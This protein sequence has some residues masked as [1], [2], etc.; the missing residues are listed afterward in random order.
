MLSVVRE[1]SSR[2]PARYYRDSRCR[3][4][5]I[6]GPDLKLAGAPPP[7]LVRRRWRNSRPCWPTESG[8]QAPPGH[9]GGEDV[10]DG[11]LGRTAWMLR[12]T[13]M[14]GTRDAACAR[15]RRGWRWRGRGRGNRGCPRHRRRRG[16]P[17]PALPESAPPSDCPTGSSISV[18][19]CRRSGLRGP[20]DRGPMHGASAG[21][22]R[23]AE[24]RWGRAAGAFAF[25]PAAAGHGA[26][27]RRT[28]RAMI[29]GV[30][31]P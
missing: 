23:P 11:S 26:W 19:E 6:S 30:V 16:S 7:G 4:C 24:E 27:Q 1:V 13:R 31:A 8:G 15:R 17:R 9:P 22:R 20:A 21:R 25:R 12:P 3:G 29:R 5:P 18:R 28:G 10:P 14:G 2:P